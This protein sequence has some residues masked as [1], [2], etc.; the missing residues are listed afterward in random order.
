M[1]ANLRR[2]LLRLV[3]V[4]GLC[5]INGTWTVQRLALTVQAILTLPLE[6]HI[7]LLV[8]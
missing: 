5:P 1:L 4:Q 6:L 3:A 7:Q 2:L 8:R